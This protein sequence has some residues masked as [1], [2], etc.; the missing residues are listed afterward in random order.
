MIAVERGGNYAS[1]LHIMREET[2]TITAS[3]NARQYTGILSDDITYN[4]N[5]TYPERDIVHVRFRNYDWTERSSERSRFGFATS[6]VELLKRSLEITNQLDKFV[7]QFFKSNVNG[8]RMKVNATVPIGKEAAR[9]FRE[10]VEQEAEDRKGI[11]YLRNGLDI[12]QIQSTAIDQ[13][14]G[15]LREFQIKE[16][17]RIFGV[18]E[19][20]L[21]SNKSGIPIEVAMRDFFVNGLK[22]HVN[23]FLNAMT[24]TML[25][26]DPKSNKKFRFQI[27]ESELIRGNIQSIASLINVAGGDAQRFAYMNSAEIRKMMGLPEI[28]EEDPNKEMM[29]EG[30]KQRQSM[31]QAAGAEGGAESSGPI[32]ETDEEK[33]K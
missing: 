5:N 32:A 20:M 26:R 18:P 8:L 27:D 13:S 3:D 7:L 1:S 24:H 31:F 4:D 19:F 25:N 2:T 17:A 15:V 11:V 16:V 6:P 23:A 9:Q 22:P 29:D 30:I 14:M 33:D 21:S 12:N 10:Y 28:M